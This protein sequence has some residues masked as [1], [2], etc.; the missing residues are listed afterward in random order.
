VANLLRSTI[1]S[2]LAAVVP[3]FSIRVLPDEI[4]TVQ[5]V[6]DCGAWRS[7]P[8]LCN[9]AWTHSPSNDPTTPPPLS[10]FALCHPAS[11]D[12]LRAF[13]LSSGILTGPTLPKSA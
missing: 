1:K 9:L 6:K 10:I 4:E 11:L 8:C 2:W 7:V 12:L 13:S 5:L 3:F